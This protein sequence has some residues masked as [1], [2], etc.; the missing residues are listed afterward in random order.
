MQYN[1]RIIGTNTSAI[2][3]FDGICNLC[4]RSVDFTLRNDR[5]KRIKF[6]PFQSDAGHKLL[7]DHGICGRESESI[8]L[9]ANDNIYYR[10]DAILNVLRILG[11][12]W[13]FLYAFIILPRGFRDWI[14]TIIARNR[15]KWFG[16]R[17]NCRKP[18]DDVVERF[19]R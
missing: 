12:M 9:I 18:E 1:K 8:I 16:K 11:G 4:N 6:V 10:S 13:K 14:Y 3:I 19:L 2:L 5:K 15:Y 17:D 7:E